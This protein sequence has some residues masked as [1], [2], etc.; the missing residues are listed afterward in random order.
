MR[1]SCGTFPLVISPSSP[2]GSPGPGPHRPHPV[3]RAQQISGSKDRA[4]T[5]D[6]GTLGCSRAGHRGMSIRTRQGGGQRPG[7]R[8]RRRQHDGP[9]ALWGAAGGPGAGRAPGVPL[10]MMAMP[11]QTLGDAGDSQRQSSSLPNSQAPAQTLPSPGKINGLRREPRTRLRHRPLPT[12]LPPNQHS[13]KSML[14]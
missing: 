3:L 14:T 4:W 11:S 1:G 6:Q 5:M 10:T 9:V 8:G 12:A 7:W 2:S 13:S